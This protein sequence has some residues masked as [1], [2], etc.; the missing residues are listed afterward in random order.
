MNRRLT[1]TLTLVLALGMVAVTGCQKKPPKGA[2]QVQADQQRTPQED[3]AAP[4]A[5]DGTVTVGSLTAMLPAGWQSVAP[6]APMRKAELLIPNVNRDGI[7]GFITVF[8][9][10]PQA[11]SVDMNIERWA[12]QFE[13][14]NGQPLTEKMVKRKTFMANGLKVTLVSFTGTQ[15]PSQMPGGAQMHP[16]KKFMNISGIVLTPEGPWFFKGT[17]PEKLMKANKSG[18]KSFLSSMVYHGSEAVNPSSDTQSMGN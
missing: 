10:G 7:P 15:R 18:F 6:S 2:Q 17:G 14:T 13:Q 4:V 12:G 16:M 1:L 5:A 8:Y 9:F 3:G 11:G